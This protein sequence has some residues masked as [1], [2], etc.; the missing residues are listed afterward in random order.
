MSLVGLIK[1]LLFIIRTAADNSFRP[2]AL[3]ASLVGGP[4]KFILNTHSHGD[5]SGG[6]DH[7]IHR[8]ALLIDDAINLTG[9]K[10]L[11]VQSHSAVV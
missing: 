6:N 1:F 7:F 5:H 10:D 9:I 8:G 11:T 4:A 2:T 3:L